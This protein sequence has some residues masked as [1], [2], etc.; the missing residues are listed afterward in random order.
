MHIDCQLVKISL[1]LGW[2][3]LWVGPFCLSP[4]KDCSLCPLLP[5][6]RIIM[7]SR[8]TM[9]IHSF[10]SGGRGRGGM[11]KAIDFPLCSFDIHPIDTWSVEWGRE[12]WL[13]LSGY[14]YRLTSHGRLLR[15]EAFVSWIFRGVTS[16]LIWVRWNVDETRAQ[17]DSKCGRSNWTFFC[18]GHRLLYWMRSH[19]CGSG[20]FEKLGL[21]L[22]SLG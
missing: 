12:S 16:N 21:A 3:E 18:H 6:F 2:K 13:M 11:L 20:C 15:G 8:R 1:E 10:L 22:V 5:F 7:F 17:F 9:I 19:F 14:Y 4:Y